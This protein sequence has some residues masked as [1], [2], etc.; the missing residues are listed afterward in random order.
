MT[1]YAHVYC[2]PR[3]HLRRLFAAVLLAMAPAAI[4]VHAQD[5][6][7]QEGIEVSPPQQSWR[8]VTGIVREEVLNV[9]GVPTPA[10]VLEESTDS[11]M[12][13]QLTIPLDAD[14]L[15]VQLVPLR[16]GK[17]DSFTLSFDR[18][19]FF[20][21]PGDVPLDARESSTIP[22]DIPMGHL[23]GHAG[24]LEAC[25]NSSGE[26]NSSFAVHSMEFIELASGPPPG[27]YDDV[28]AATMSFLR[29]TLHDTIDDHVR[30]PYT[31]GSTDTWDILELADQDPGNSANILDVYKNASYPK[32]GGNNNYNREHTWPNSYG[33]PDDGASN[34]PYTDCHALFLSNSSYNS[35]RGNN[36]FR[37]CSSGCTERPTDLTNGQG[38]GT[39]I[40]PGNS[41]WRTGSGS[42]GSWETWRGRRG[43]VARALFYLDVRYEGGTHGETGVSEPD[44]ILT[45][46]ASLI[47]TSGGVNAPVADM[48]ILTTLLAWH[49]EDPVDDRERHRNQVV[50][51]FQENRNPFIDHPEWVRCAF[52]GQCSNVIFSDDF[53]SGNAEVWVI[54][55]SN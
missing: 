39:G 55:P 11:A 40:Y 24:I 31:S 3:M 6:G 41:N 26:A 20:S 2:G 34:Y 42:T 29:T 37:S 38:G 23:K 53:E 44:L 5:F 47:Q 30:F 18:E 27:Y 51:E 36:P 14:L 54:W 17:G 7:F 8:R 15:H 52:E 48:G 16:P 9:E 49:V 1:R 45:N 28:D 50:S 21:Y 13:L 25:L 35:S 46:D 33:F 22:L 19:V 32:A 4:Q 12:D 10:F 43:D